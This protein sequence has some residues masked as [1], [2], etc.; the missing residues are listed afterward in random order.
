M[1]KIVFLVVFSIFLTGCDSEVDKCVKAR[2][3]SDEI[4]YK[5]DNGLSGQRLKD[6]MIHQ[7]SHNRTVCN[8]IVNKK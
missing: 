2:M 3:A 8:Q 4:F 7:E 5:K 6:Q 1:I